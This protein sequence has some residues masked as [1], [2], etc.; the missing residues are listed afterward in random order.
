MTKLE[1]MTSQVSKFA[2]GGVAAVVA[3]T[4]FGASAM[5]AQ[6]P[7]TALAASSAASAAPEVRAQVVAETSTTIGAPM[8]GRLSQFPLHDGERF[9]QG[10]VIARFVCAE[11][12]STLV[13]ARAVYDGRKTV[14]DSKQRL[15]ALGTSSEVEYKVAE[16]DEEEAAADVKTAQTVVDNCT[17]AAPFTGRV[18]AVYTHNFQFLQTGAPMLD[19]LSDKNLNVEMIVP[20][21]WLTWL[22][23]GSAFNVAIDETGKSYPATL[24]RLSGKVDAVSRSIKVYGRIDNPPDTLLPGMSGR[25]LFTPP[26]GATVAARQ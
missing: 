16:S 25:A 3:G 18:S 17:V 22:K 23:P 12:E 21:M 8:S 13:H 4:L 11:K 24:V 1:L 9:K 2:R 20:S 19:V 14:N 7:A 15:R 6:S 5:A 10:Q 26:A